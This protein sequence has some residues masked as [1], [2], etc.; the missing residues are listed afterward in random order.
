MKI[1]KP[2]AYFIFYIGGENMSW[3]FGLPDSIY[4]L[5]YFHDLLVAQPGQSAQMIGMKSFLYNLAQD[6]MAA[7]G[8][9]DNSS[10][11]IQNSLTFLNQIAISER[12]IC[13]NQL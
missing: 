8:N 9:F 6:E 10:D 5:T 1:S 13:F 11:N 4:K 3:N 12:N 2:R 7:I